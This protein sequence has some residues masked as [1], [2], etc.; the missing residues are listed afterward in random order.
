[1]NPRSACV[2]YC[3]TV[4]NYTAAVYDEFLQFCQRMTN[5]YVIGK[6]VGNSGTPH[7]QCFIALKQKERRSKLSNMLSFKP[8]FEAAL[9]DGQTASDYCK[10]GEQSHEEWVSLKTLGPNFGKNADFVEFGTIPNTAKGLG[11]V[12]ADYGAAIELAKKRKFNEIDPS[13][14]IRHYGNLQRISADNPEKV[15]DLEDVCGV[16]IY[17]PSG[18]GKS[19]TARQLYP[20][21]Y[22]KACNKW[23]DGYEGQTA[24]IIDDFDIRHECLGHH[25]KRWADKYAFSCEVK[26]T[27]R[28]IRPKHIVV[29][30]NYH[31]NQIWKDNADLE[32]ILRRFTLKWMN[33]VYRRDEDDDSPYANFIRSTDEVSTKSTLIIDEFRTEDILNHEDY[34]RC[35]SLPIPT[36]PPRDYEPTLIEDDIFY[37]DYNNGI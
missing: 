32:P 3:V 37:I 20:D 34:L 7:L 18:T 17:G 2:F 27:T 31:P 14:L 28:F 33:E 35:D 1:M 5:Y 26:G 11:K 30:S 10:K 24:W 19:H 25:L 22:D 8:H 16:W 4:N 13:I 9:A 12:K 23:A 36:P 21:F 29:T 6:E 15:E